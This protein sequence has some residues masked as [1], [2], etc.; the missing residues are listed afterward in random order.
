MPQEYPR[1]FRRLL[2][3]EVR[4]RSL[5]DFAREQLANGY[6][7]LSRIVSR[8]TNLYLGTFFLI[9]PEGFV[10]RDIENWNW[11]P[12]GIDQ[13]AADSALAQ[14]IA[15]YLKGTGTRVL[16]QDF[17]RSRSD[18]SFVDDPLRAF[19][20]EKM[21][22]ELQGS[23]IS[24]EKISSCIS[25]ASYWPWFGYFCAS[26]KL[27]KKFLNERDLEEVAATLVG[28]AIQALHDSYVLWWRT[29]LAAFPGRPER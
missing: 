4:E 3:G 18:S 10:P 26:R 1:G 16:I 15:N 7:E 17:E 23:D 8:K 28:V 29:D 5:F 14:L 19:Y 21:Y 20:G 12:G 2:V 11:G 27:P 9:M 22:W 24:T 13:L 25:D 6:T